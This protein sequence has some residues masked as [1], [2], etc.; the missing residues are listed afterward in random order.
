ME[1]GLRNLSGE[2]SFMQKGCHEDLKVNKE[3]VQYATSAESFLGPGNT[4]K[5]TQGSLTKWLPQA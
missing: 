2:L 5:R 1:A 3:N 4:P